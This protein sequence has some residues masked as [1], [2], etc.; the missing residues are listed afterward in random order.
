[1]AFVLSELAR[2]G[3][4]SAKAGGW[5]SQEDELLARGRAVVAEA[6]ID[7]GK[8]QLQREK[9]YLVGVAD[10]DPGRHCVGSLPA[11]EHDPGDT[12]ASDETY[13][14][15]RHVVPPSGCGSWVRV[16]AP[17]DQL[18]RTLNR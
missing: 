9:A 7:R 18:T 10:S 4:E 6:D 12:S 3:S 15:D 5:S 13:G 8:V 14:L 16:G 2:L 11:L 1:M 17:R